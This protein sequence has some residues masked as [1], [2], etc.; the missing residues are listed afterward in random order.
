M[1]CE[2]ISNIYEEIINLM[3]EQLHVYSE[4]TDSVNFDIEDIQRLSEMD[5]KIKELKKKV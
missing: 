4:Y 3:G 5:V 2:E 1:T